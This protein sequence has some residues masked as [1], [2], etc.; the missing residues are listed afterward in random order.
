MYQQGK[1]FKI[2]KEKEKFVTMVKTFK[3]NKTTMIL[4]INIVK[5]IEKSIKEISNENLNEFK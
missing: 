1:L 5:M 4:K 3:V 2:F